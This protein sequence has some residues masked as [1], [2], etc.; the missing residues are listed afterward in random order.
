MVVYSVLLGVGS[1]LSMQ[2][3]M[4]AVQGCAPPAQIGAVTATVTYARLV[5]ASFGISAFG[6][7]FSARLATELPRHVP[8]DSAQSMT[9]LTADALDKLPRTCGR[10][11]PRPTPTRWAPSSSS[12]CPSCCSLSYCRSRCATARWESEEHA[13]GERPEADPGVGKAVEGDLHG[14]GIHRVEELVGQD[15]RNC[16]TG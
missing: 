7:V 14:M 2:V 3:F 1:G 8:G 6:A 11:S 5:G 4:V 15:P 9:N 16:T 12:R 13:H 10:A